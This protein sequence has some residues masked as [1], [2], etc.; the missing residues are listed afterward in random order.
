[1]VVHAPV[2]SFE[3][4][5]RKNQLRRSSPLTQ[6]RQTRRSISRDAGPLRSAGLSEPASIDSRLQALYTLSSRFHNLSR[7]QR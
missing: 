2:V 4:K 3:T 5:D 6:T 7:S 1:M